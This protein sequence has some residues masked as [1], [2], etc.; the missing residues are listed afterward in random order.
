MF[1]LDDYVTVRLLV[2][3]PTAIRDRW[4]HQY[5]ETLGQA[6]RQGAGLLCGGPLMRAGRRG[7]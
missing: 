4:S 2:W 3:E 5:D 1:G 6:L 7:R